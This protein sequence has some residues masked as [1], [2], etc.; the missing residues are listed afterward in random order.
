MF[1]DG[2]LNFIML[3]PST[4]TEH[5]ND[6]TVARCERIALAGGYETMVV[7]NLFA[8]RAT[9]PRT[10]LEHPEP[11]GAE[12]CK[13]IFETAKKARRIICAWGNHGGHLGRS[14]KVLGMLEGME[15]FALRLNGSGEPAHPLY[16][17]ASLEAEL[18]RRV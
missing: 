6:P 4:A 8:I 13:A 7:T 14:G 5:F 9:D 18:W 10:M 11:V 16:L 1:G 2:L 12:N 17:P 3:N 15:L